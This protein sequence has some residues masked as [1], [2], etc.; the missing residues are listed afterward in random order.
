[1]GITTGGQLIS[2]LSLMSSRSP[3]QA[4]QPQQQAPM[5]SS[6]YASMRPDQSR[7]GLGPENF[8]NTQ[9]RQAPP[10]PA[11]WQD[12]THLLRARYGAPPLPTTP[13]QDAQNAVNDP[14]SAN[15]GWDDG[16]Q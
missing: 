12:A 13:F 14:N 5:F 11:T 6:Y 9:N 15:I 16:R 2:L 7:G 10:Q 1:M 8:Q 4:E 3:T